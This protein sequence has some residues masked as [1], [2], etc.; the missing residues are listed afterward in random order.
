[1]HVNINRSTPTN[2]LRS[3]NR[4]KVDICWLLT[5]ED[6]YPM[7]PDRNIILGIDGVMEAYY[8]FP[9][10]I[11][12]MYAPDP[13][14]EDFCETLRT[15]KAKGVKGCG[16]LKVSLRWGSKGINDLLRCASKLNLP[17]LFHME[18]TPRVFI[19]DSQTKV[20]KLINKL[21]NSE[22]MPN[23]CKKVVRKVIEKMDVKCRLS[24]DTVEYLTDFNELEEKL[25]QYKDIVFIGHGPFLWKNIAA[26][27][28]EDI[29]YNKG[30]VASKGILWDLLEKY[31]NFYADLSGGSGFYALHR[32]RENA[33][34]FLNKYYDKILYGTDNFNL[35]LDTLLD[36][37]KLPHYKLQ[38]IYGLNAQNILEKMSGTGFD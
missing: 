18:R 23:S 20:D 8:N 32:D 7:I 19:Q 33:K 10:R 5:W 13:R 24:F 15:Y 16:E 12:P 36:S 17:V 31:D 1:M 4:N 30:P 3:L 28:S 27:Y 38:R 6:L 34:Q 35:G 14:K 21:L 29:M 11:V 2:I 26:I 22:T 25:I 9:D 37:L